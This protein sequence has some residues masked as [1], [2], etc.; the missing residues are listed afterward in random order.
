ME[1]TTLPLLL[2]SIPILFLLL[3]LISRSPPSRTEQQALRLPP[4][5]WQLP[6]VGSLHHLLLSRSR[7]LPHQAMRELSTTYGPLMLLRLGAVPTLVVSSAEAAREVLK[8]H[9]VSFCARQ[10]SVTLDIASRGGRGIVF[11]PY[12]DRWRELRKVC[13]LELFNQRRV[14]SFR[15]VR[16]EEV[17]RLVRSISGEC[18]GGGGCI[19]L[20]DKITRM[21]TDTVVRTTIGRRLQQQDEFLRYLGKALE[22]SGGFNLADL[23]PSWRLTRLLSPTIRDLVKYRRNIDGIIE[24]II[25]EHADKPKPERE[26]LLSVLLRLQKNGGLQFPLTTEHICT[27]IFD[28]FAA[29][30]ETSSTTLDWVMSE[31]MKNPKVFH[32]AQLEVRKIFKGREK[33][34]EQDIAK[35]SYLQLVIKETLRLHAPA[36]LLI[37]RECRET[38]Q[39]MGYDVPKGTAVL[40]NVW[41]IGR[42]N[43]YWDD[44]NLFKPERFENSKIDFRGAN[45][46]YLPFGAG[47][48]ICP[49]LMLGL[50]NIELALASLLYH[51]D[52]E[53]PSGIKSEE[54]DMTEAS[55]ITVRRKAKLWLRAKPHNTCMN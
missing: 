51:F 19:N 46:E 9:D 54:L 43:K 1:L 48:R 44:P 6:L 20:S 49:G 50:A 14:L 33:L 47:R 28:I 36:P 5:P 53:L 35:L 8:T 40:V 22:L 55:G 11:S 41:A 39:V 10:R 52:W 26:D 34:N 31:L 4:G 42:D 2:L 32:K 37:P 16:E 29:G 25:R 24:S 18:S 13:V 17:A 15:P 21:V 7:E 38:C 30:S 12:N 45:F 23:Y 3:K 27:V